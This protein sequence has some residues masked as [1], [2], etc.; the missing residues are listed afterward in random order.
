MSLSSGGLPEEQQWGFYPNSDALLRTMP[1]PFACMTALGI[2]LT[3][4]TFLILFPTSTRALSISP[5]LPMISN[6]LI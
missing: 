1:R 5:D 2:D 4:A 6:V 3:P